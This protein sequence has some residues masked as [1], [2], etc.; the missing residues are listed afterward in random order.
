MTKS[1]LE[2]EVA[3]LKAQVTTLKAVVA[4]LSCPS[5]IKGFLAFPIPVQQQAAVNEWLRNNFS[6][7]Y[8]GE[9]YFEGVRYCTFQ[10]SGCRGDD[11]P[12]PFPS[13]DTR[14]MVE[15]SHTDS[16]GSYA[17]RAWFAVPNNR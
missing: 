6:S 10:P 4:R 7:D 13:D 3:A 17:H 11:F 8:H 12:V 9:S 16:D 14:L 2:S 1:Q 15:F 5:H